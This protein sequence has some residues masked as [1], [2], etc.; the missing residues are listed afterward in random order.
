LVGWEWAAGLADEPRQGLALDE[1]HDQERQ[2][3]VLAVVEDGGD[4]GVDQSRRVQR[5]VA[6]AQGEQLLVFG[7]GAH[8]LERDQSLQDCVR[9]DPYVAHATGRDACF[10]SVPVAEHEPWLQPIHVVGLTVRSSTLTVAPSEDGHRCRRRGEGSCPL[11]PCW[12]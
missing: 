6:E 1:L 11:Y 5:L 3:L 8:H 12:R 2:A 7:V 10:K 9:R 4:V